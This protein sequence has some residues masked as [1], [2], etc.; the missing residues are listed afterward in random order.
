MIIINIINFFLKLLINLIAIFNRRITEKNWNNWFI[1][2]QRN[3]IFQSR[4][5]IFFS[6]C[7][8]NPK[9][10][11]TFLNTL[12]FVLFFFHNSILFNNLLFSIEIKVMYSVPNKCKIISTPIL[13]YDCFNLIVSGDC[14]FWTV[15]PFLSK[16]NMKWNEMIH[17]LT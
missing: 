14:T 2:I 9:D 15:S 16:L 10:K 3:I 8:N 17:V 12:K 4:I 5:S 11:Y 13:L 6:S 7:S 1:F